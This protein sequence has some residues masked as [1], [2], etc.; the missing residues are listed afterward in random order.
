MCLEGT[1]DASE[2]AQT[3]PDC[4]LAAT[5]SFADGLLRQ[6]GLMQLHQGQSQPADGMDLPPGQSRDLLAMPLAASEFGGGVPAYSATNASSPNRSD[7][8]SRRSGA[9]TS[10]GTAVGQGGST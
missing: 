3:M 5:E 7:R 1:S 9:V 8:V 4:T 10:R 6:S 2:P